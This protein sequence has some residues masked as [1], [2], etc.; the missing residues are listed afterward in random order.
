MCFIRTVILQ[1]IQTYGKKRGS[2]R[3]EVSSGDGENRRGAPGFVASETASSV[4]WVLPSVFPCVPFFTVCLAALVNIPV[5][6]KHTA[7]QD[8]ER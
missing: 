2:I 8:E 3:N 5:R 7:Q 6:V 4:A 1:R